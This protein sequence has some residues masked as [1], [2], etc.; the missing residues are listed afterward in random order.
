MI[1]IDVVLDFEQRVHFW[2][3]QHGIRGSR[4]ALLVNDFQE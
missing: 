1:E 2:K 4:S 3:S